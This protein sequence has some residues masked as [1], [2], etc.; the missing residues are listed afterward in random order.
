[1]GMLNEFTSPLPVC[2]TD[3]HDIVDV[4][5]VTRVESHALR[6]KACC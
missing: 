3:E 6:I 1:M 4:L 5:L 2:H